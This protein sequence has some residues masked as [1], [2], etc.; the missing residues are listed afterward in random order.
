MLNSH[1]QDGYNYLY[2]ILMTVF[3]RLPAPLAVGFFSD[4]IQPL[5]DARPHC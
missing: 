5:S 2:T 4:Q 3:R 1:F